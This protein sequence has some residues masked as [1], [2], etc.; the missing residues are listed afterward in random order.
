MSNGVPTAQLLMPHLA[1]QEALT[2]LMRACVH[3][4]DKDAIDK[5][6]SFRRLF[7]LACISDCDP[8]CYLIG[9]HRA[10]LRWPQMTMQERT[11]SAHWLIRQGYSTELDTVFA[12]K[13]A[14]EKPE[15]SR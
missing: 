12:P 3:V 1:Y 5:I 10:R 15:S 8:Q 9:L 13:A 2:R 6:I 11:W 7:G 4:P 14:P